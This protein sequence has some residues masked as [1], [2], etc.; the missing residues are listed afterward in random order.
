MDGQRDRVGIDNVQ[1]GCTSVG[2]QRSTSPP[3]NVCAIHVGNALLRGSVTDV[4]SA[5]VTSCTWRGWCE[6]K[7][8]TVYRE[9]NRTQQRSVIHSDAISPH[10]AHLRIF[11]LRYTNVLIIIIIIILHI[12][13]M[14]DVLLPSCQICLLL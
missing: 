11:I 5:S 3:T 9:H 13:S 1:T 12:M 2:F 4:V 14:P 7:R 6:L 10:L 8:L